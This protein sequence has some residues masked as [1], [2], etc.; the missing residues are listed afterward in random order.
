MRFMES[1]N[2]SRIAHRAHEAIPDP[3]HEGN[4]R[5]TSAVLLPSLEGSGVAW[6]MEGICHGNGNWGKQILASG[7]SVWL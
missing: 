2:D 1:L 5:R 4:C 6:L 7:D 3:S